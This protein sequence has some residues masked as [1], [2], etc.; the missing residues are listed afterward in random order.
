MQRLGIRIVVAGLAVIGCLAAMPRDAAALELLESFDPGAGELPESI[1]LDEAGN[2]YL[3][4]SD[5]VRKIAT[6]G[7]MTTFG[8]LPI[9]AFA[10]GVQ[11]GPDGCVYT[12]STSLNP[13]VEGAFV[14]RMC[15]AGQVE[16]FAELDHSG[17]PNDLAFGRYGSLFVTDTALGRIWKVTPDGNASVWL[18]DPLLDGIPDDP[19]LQFAPI[20]ADGIAF[21]WAKRNIYVTNLDHGCIVRIRMRWDGSPGQARNFTCDPALVG[22][23]GIAFDAAQRLYVAVGSQDQLVRVGWWGQV[24]IVEEGGLLAGPSSV[25][26]GTTPEDKHSL[27]IT[28]LDFLKAFGFVPGTPE[29]GLLRKPVFVPG[30]PLP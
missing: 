18:D 9:D 1:A 16:V 28:N 2:I 27:Y 3:S 8:T 10:L 15:E 4:M 5:T 17:A 24:E 29:P 12:A 30:I 7:T 6:D 20:G 25:A 14:W 13:A 19:I 22:A 26:F 11:V 21:D 23:D